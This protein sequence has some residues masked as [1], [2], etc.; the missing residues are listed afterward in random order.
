MTVLEGLNLEPEIVIN[1]LSV[2]FPPNNGGDPI[3]ALKNINLDIKQGEFISL[4]GPSGCGKTT[5]LRTIADLH[6]GGYIHP[7]TFPETDSVG[8]ETGHRV[9]ITGAV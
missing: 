1:D 9:P 6:I 3:K 2:V 7:R 4:V 5:L 8:E